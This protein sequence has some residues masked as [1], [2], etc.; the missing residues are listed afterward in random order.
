[1]STRKIILRA[2]C[3]GFSSPMLGAFSK[4][5]QTRLASARRVARRNLAKFFSD[6]AGRAR[7]AAGER[8]L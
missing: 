6:P 1:M 5:P 7:P 4:A 2:G 3:G 8:H